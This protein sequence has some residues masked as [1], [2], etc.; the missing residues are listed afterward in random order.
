MGYAWPMIQLYKYIW[1]RLYLH[2]RRY[3]SEAGP[4]M[5]QSLAGVCALIITNVMTVVIW[6]QILTGSQSIL[7]V[8]SMPKSSLAIFSLLPAAVFLLYWVPKHKYK[9]IIY[10]FDEIMS[11]GTKT[12]K[13]LYS[14]ASWGYQIITWGLFIAGIVVLRSFSH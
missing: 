14:L 8:A 13:L 3:W 11:R 4:A 7:Y 5:T 2:N 6:V 12:Q 1:Y 10:E 9:E